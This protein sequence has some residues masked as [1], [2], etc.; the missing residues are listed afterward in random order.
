MT[1]IA[2]P[3]PDWYVYLLSTYR[4]AGAKMDFPRYE[5][6]DDY[7]SFE[8]LQLATAKDIY[9]ET[10]LCYPGFAIRDLGYICLATD[11]TGSGDPY[12]IKVTD[13]DNPPVYQVY[14]DVSDIGTVIEREGMEMMADSLAE[15]F[16]KARVGGR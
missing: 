4:L 8:P 14:H 12:F 5:T 16:M 7:D 15:F 2:P 10:E 9:S 11:L 1:R 6:K 13:G 3:M